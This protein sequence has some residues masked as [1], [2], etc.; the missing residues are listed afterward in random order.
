MQSRLGAQGGGPGWVSATIYTPQGGVLSREQPVVCRLVLQGLFSLTLPLGGGLCFGP[1]SCPPTPITLGALTG[2][3][4][5]PS[6]PPLAWG[7]RSSSPLRESRLSRGR[8][9]SR[10]QPCSNCED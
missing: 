7:L 6:S 5:V 8:E 1:Q 9:E 3:E 4:C 2:Q 10:G